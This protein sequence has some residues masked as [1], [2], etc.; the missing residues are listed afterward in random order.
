MKD[1]E[2]ATLNLAKELHFDF[3]ELLNK[4]YKGFTIFLPYRNDGVIPCYGYPMYI[5]VDES[6]V[7]KWGTSIF[8]NPDDLFDL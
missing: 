4:K 5:F 7:A 2:L 8:S 6:N 3:V 1:K